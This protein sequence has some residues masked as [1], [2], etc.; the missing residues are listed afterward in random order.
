MPNKDINCSYEYRA[1]CY[2][3]SL[4]LCKFCCY[5]TCYIFPYDTFYHILSLFYDMRMGQ[6]IC[7]SI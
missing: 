3:L 6:R 2:A 5:Y 4:F 7:I 1:I